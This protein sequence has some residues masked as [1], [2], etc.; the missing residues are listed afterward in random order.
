[1]LDMHILYVNMC[2]CLHTLSGFSKAYFSLFCVCIFFL[3]VCMRATCVSCT[4]G[5]QSRVLD[6]LELETTRSSSRVTSVH[7]SE[8]IPPAPT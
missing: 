3:N 6:S 4:P 7:N 1:M 8:A 2:F 5:G